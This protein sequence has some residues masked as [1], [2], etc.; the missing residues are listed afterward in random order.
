MERTT[1][2]LPSAIDRRAEIFRRL[3]GRPVALFLDYDGTLTPI[4]E[5]P[6]MAV[7]SP[8]MRATVARA[9]RCCTVAVVS[10]RDL[11]DV[12]A[13]VGVEAI[14]YAGSHGFEIAGPSHGA[15]D[16]AL[17]HEQGAAFLP[18]LDVVEQG[19]RERLAAV[20]G[21]R[22]ERKR[23]AIAVHYR[24]VE[25]AEAG[26]VRRIVAEVVG[27]HP[28]LHS[29]AGKKVYDLQP[30]IDWHKGKA[31]LWLLAALGLD[32]PEVAPIYIGDDTTDETAFR[33]LADR[34]VGIIVRDGER[35]TSAQ[36]A[37]DGVA[38]VRDFLEA[39]IAEREAG[40]GAAGG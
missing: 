5:D 6:K 14:V 35:T 39:L 7:L 24:Q 12:Q 3:H 2:D 1:T 25:P 18:E 28:K 32:R 13:M 22:V 23:F 40:E 19:L 29:A 30:A 31:V 34:G 21:A 9:A 16:R 10:G 37:L 17:R 8:A 38:Q 33:A 36:Y 4:V 11:R 27:Q 15:G 20:K 26:E